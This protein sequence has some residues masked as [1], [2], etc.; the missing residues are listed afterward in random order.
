MFAHRISG[1]VFAAAL[2]A[3]AACRSSKP[4]TDTPTT[5]GPNVVTV[6]ASDFQFDAPAE[7]PAGLTIFRLVNNGPGLH[8]AQLMRLEQGKTADDFIAALKAGG[9][10]APWA[11][12]AGGPNPPEVGRTAST[13]V[14][15]EPGNYAII[16]FIPSADGTPHFMKGM[17]RSLKVTAPTRA[18]VAEPTADVVVKLVDFDFELSAPLTAGRHT[19]RIENTG[20]Q[21]HEIAL[22]QLKPGKEPLDFA[23]W[24]EKQE[25]PAPGTLFGGVSGIMPGTHSFAMVDLPA[26]DYALLCFL[27]DGKDG[28]PHFMHGMAKKIKVS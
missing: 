7:S 9:P 18:A 5:A 20:A 12:P 3:L 1:G 13:T 6:T 16:C 27:P 15:L 17:V 14:L 28:K 11:I 21:P 19:L 4:A 23:A 10:P 22:V 2:I 8:H 24:G 25:G 26:G